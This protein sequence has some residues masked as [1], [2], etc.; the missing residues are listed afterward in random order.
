MKFI[1]ILF[2][3]SSSVSEAQ[4]VFSQY[5]AVIDCTWPCLNTSHTC[6]IT[7]Q[8]AQCQFQTPNSWTMISPSKAPM[9]TGASVSTNLQSCTLAPQAPLPT[10]LNNTP[11]LNHQS[12]IMWPVHNLYRPL[13]AYLGNCGHGLYCSSAGQD[14][15]QPI[16]RQKSQYGSHC[17][18]SNQCLAGV[19]EHNVCRPKDRRTMHPSNAIADHDYLAPIVGSVLGVLGTVGVAVMCVYVY[20]RYYKKP[21]QEQESVKFKESQFASDFLGQSSGQPLPPSYQ[22]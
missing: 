17:V 20:R 10:L 6:I 4:E 16:C 7:L 8:T 13:D 21:E 14:R 19:C 5:P 15:Q 22:P 11:L 12:I 1:F 2:L 9:Y 18:S 3:I